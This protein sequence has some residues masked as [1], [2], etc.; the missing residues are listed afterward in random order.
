MDTDEIT[1]LR[2]AMDRTADGLPQ[3]PDLVP[4]AVREGRRRRVR[5]RLAIVTIAFGAITAGALGL[6][7]LPGSNTDVTMPA[8]TPS[9]PG[10][11]ASAQPSRS[12]PPVVVTQ[13]PGTTSP[14]NPDNP[15]NLSEA[16][17][18]RRAAHQQRVAALLDELLPPTVTEI[19]PVKDEVSVYRIKAGG[20]T[21]RMTVSVRPADKRTVPCVSRPERHYVCEVTTLTYAT[22]REAQLFSSGG[23][24]QDSQ[25]S[26][27]LRFLYSRSRVALGVDSDAGKV[28]VTPRQLLV[29]VKDPRFLD[30]LRDTDVK[31][32]EGKL[33]PPVTGG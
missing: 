21:F 13:T 26:S 1:L 7:L 31:P 24:A 10:A 18:E 27:Y 3:L 5:A 22:N 19:R 14:D 28:P 9:S 20:E 4:L 33:P 17:R 11:S 6:T 8:V 16:E 2:A 15:D 23:G 12:Y 30:L 32:V 29:V 25:S